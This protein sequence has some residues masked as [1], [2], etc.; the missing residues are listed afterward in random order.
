VHRAWR[1]SLIQE[2]P[3]DDEI[4]VSSRGNAD[5]GGFTA[6]TATREFADFSDGTRRS[7]TGINLF[8]HAGANVPVKHSLDFMYLV[9]ESDDYSR[10]EAIALISALGGIADGAVAIIGAIAGAAAATIGAITGGIAIVV[11]IIIVAVLL[12]PSAP[13][14]IGGQLDRFTAQQLQMRTASGASR[15]SWAKPG[16]RAAHSLTFG[17]HFIVHEP[18]G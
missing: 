11:G 6:E 7:F 17:F 1:A 10:S 14:L 3:G 18:S 15:W 8:S 16:W 13:S 4:V 5:N 12:D 9:M 2:Y